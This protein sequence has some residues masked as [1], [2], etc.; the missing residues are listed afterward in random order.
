MKRL[1][2]RHAGLYIPVRQQDIVFATIRDTIVSI[3]TLAFSGTVEHTS[4]NLLATELDQNMFC[5]CHRGW[6]VNIDRISEIHDMFHG[7]RMLRM[8]D[9]A[10]TEV[11]VSRA[12]WRDLR[13]RF[14]SGSKCREHEPIEEAVIA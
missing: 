10:R 12:G 11:T 5:R 3:Q 2:V 14:I 7:G 9:Q 8:A 4:L 13:D 6:L 1:L